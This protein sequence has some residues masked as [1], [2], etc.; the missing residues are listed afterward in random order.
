MGLADSQYGYATP[1]VPSPPFLAPHGN[2]HATHARA[3]RMSTASRPAEID[4]VRAA[5]DAQYEILEEIGRGG[6]AIVYRAR[7]RELD[8]EV[9]VKVLPAQFAFDE[10]F[11]E[12]FQREGRIAAQLEHP[13]VVP[14][15]RVGRSGDV[16]YL[17][18][19]LLRGQSLSERIRQRGRLTPAEVR[20][21]LLETATALG[22]AAKRGVVHRDI[23]PDNIMLDEDGRCIVTDFGIARSA[24]ESKLTATGM[25]VGTPR[26]M[27][28]EQA[29]AQPLDGRSDIYSLGVVGYECLAGI[30]PFHGEDA[31]A[32]L[33]AH[34]NEPVPRPPL[35]GAEAHDLFRV[36]SRMLAKD[37]R[38]RFQTADEIVAAL[39]SPQPAGDATIVG[40]GA[41]VTRTVVS[42]GVGSTDRPRVESIDS[43][44]P[45]A[46]EALDRA[47][48]AGVEMLKQQKPKLDAGL[49]A[50]KAQQPR[51]G[52]G[53][54]AGRSFIAGQ[55]SRLGGVMATAARRGTATRA[56]VATRSRTFWLTAAAASI[57]GVTLYYGVHFATKHRS[58][59]PLPG[60]VAA[61]A[62]STVDAK[63][64]PAGSAP[65]QTFT[66]LVDAVGTRTP[67]GSLDVYYDVC[68][69]EPGT[70]YTA[71]LT[72][73]RNESG[74]KRL[75][76]RSVQPLTLT[77]DGRAN[78]PAERHHETFDFDD[79]PTGSYTVDLSVRD[80]AE[81]RKVRSTSFQV[82][83][84]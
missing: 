10:S 50:L 56:W 61:A 47:L 68:G 54:A 19:K 22:Y 3:T 14:I 63:A 55:K 11:V 21:I 26:Y 27:S 43:T 80:A 31:F 66:V 53:L 49:R 28:P 30:T 45:Q 5:L 39:Q 82:L 51:V 2:Q 76:G 69:L 73:T 62:A 6:M 60:A 17:A 4:I 23:K 74:L 36:I 15:H 64:A 46:S 70:A 79:M 84:R 77:V 41:D 44:G 20:R 8:R 16:V 72:V 59:C 7:E 37:P 52:A 83:N 24:S 81:R 34:I 13:H 65:A 42:P 35:E 25:S 38:D 32:I 9:A 1:G 75:L 67:G 58:R 29:R 33:M 40:W 57:A 78:G 71:Q 12:R 48:S 18:M